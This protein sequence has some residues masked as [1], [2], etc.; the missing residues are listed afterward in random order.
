MQ[1]MVLVANP[2]NLIYQSLDF[3]IARQRRILEWHEYI[4]KL[5]PFRVPMVWGVHQVLSQIA[6][7]N[8]VDLSV[9][10]YE[11][12]DLAEFDDLMVSD[13]LRDM[14]R[15][16][17]VMLTPLEN[18]RK[19]DIKRLE[20]A[21]KALAKNKTVGGYSESE[22]IMSQFKTA[23]HYVGKHKPVVPKNPVV[24]Y[25]SS[26]KLSGVDKFQA[27]EKPLRVL[28]HGMNP[29]EYMAWNDVQK[30]AHY[31]KVIWWHDH[32]ADMLHNDRMS[33]V[34][35]THDFCDAGLMAYRS[36]SGAAVYKAK[37]LDDF[38]EIYRLDPLRDSGRFWSAILKPIDK[39]R[40]LEEKKLINL[41][42]RKN[43]EA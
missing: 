30:L 21:K 24:P 4:H 20:D 36:A 42:K 5:S 43:S 33:H 19:D 40:D 29:P 11:V 9:V 6:L 2:E 12:E 17:T 3:K 38:D 10:V 26:T 35:G 25:E 41:E 28:I 7:S 37:D 31:Q 1:I 18:D 34:W 14:S 22:R 39:Q 8:L 27:D 16:K 15:Y 32:V 23:P 13:P